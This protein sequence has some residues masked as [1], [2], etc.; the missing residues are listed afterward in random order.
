ME[1]NLQLKKR[2]VKAI[3]DTLKVSKKGGSGF[4]RRSLEQGIVQDGILYF[5]GDG[6][7]VLRY[8]LK[9]NSLNGI[10]TFEALEVWYKLSTTRDLLTRDNIVSMITAVGSDDP[11]PPNNVEAFFNNE[12]SA[13]EYI[14]LNPKYFDIIARA[15]DTEFIDI[16]F[17]GTMKPIIITSAEAKNITGLL[18]PARDTR[19]RDL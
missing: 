6:Y 11:L 3:L 19:R 10:I 18:L 14:T 12:A 9:D 17:S 5:I 4:G 13:I 15:L 16:D 1:N 8:D 7:F 2:Q